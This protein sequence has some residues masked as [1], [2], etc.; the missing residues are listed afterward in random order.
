LHR[1]GPRAEDM[2]R[3]WYFGPGFWLERKAPA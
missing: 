1:G 3:V 2:D